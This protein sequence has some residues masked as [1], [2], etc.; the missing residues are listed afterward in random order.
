MDSIGEKLDW[1]KLHTILVLIFRHIIHLINNSFWG[2][3]QSHHLYC[4]Y[5]GLSSLHSF[6]ILY[7]N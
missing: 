4:H 3:L 6:S 7:F 2:R 5:Q 1:N